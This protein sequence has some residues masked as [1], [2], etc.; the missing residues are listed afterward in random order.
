MHYYLFSLGKS[1][2]LGN[3]GLCC[4]V[5]KA[6]SSTLVNYCISLLIVNKY[7]EQQA[8]H[9]TKHNIAKSVLHH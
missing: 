5:C 1:L 4:V 9:G 8:K 2:Q 7:A 3:K 6:K